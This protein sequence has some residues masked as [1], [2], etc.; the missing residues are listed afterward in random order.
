MI[1]AETNEVLSKVL[2]SLNLEAEPLGV[3][4]SWIKNKVQT[5][6]DLMDATSESVL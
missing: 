6:G 3:R 2:E 4:V 5:F 1:L